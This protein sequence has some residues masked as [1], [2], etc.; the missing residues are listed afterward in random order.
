[1]IILQ[2][3]GSLAV[4]EGGRRGRV[5]ETGRRSAAGFER[6]GGALLQGVQPL[7]AGNVRKEIPPG[8]SRRNQPCPQPN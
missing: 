7:E 6:G 4:K 2:T 5:R 3:Q 8:T 1:M